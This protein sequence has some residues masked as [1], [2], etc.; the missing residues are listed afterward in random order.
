MTLIKPLGASLLLA[1]WCS[2]SLA[3]EPAETTFRDY[4]DNE[5]NITLPANARLNWVHLGS[6]V[7]NDADAP[8]AGFH[9]VYT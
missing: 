5:G 9:D 2:L 1:G 7:V 8:G 6:W 3:A 4:V